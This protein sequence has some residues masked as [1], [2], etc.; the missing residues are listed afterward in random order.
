M[1]RT[2]KSKPKAKRVEDSPQV[3]A[4]EPKGG[5]AQTAE[6]A[7]PPAPPQA[8][9]AAAAEDS[10]K[11]AQTAEEAGAA[12][13]SEE[14]AQD[15]ALQPVAELEAELAQAKDQL[16]RA[17]AETE[18]VRRRARRDLEDASKYAIAVFAKSL[19]AVADN[20]R[21]ALDSIPATGS[22]KPA[23]AGEEPAEAGEE[24]A[25]SGEE[26]KLLKHLAEGV[27]I[28]E[29]ELLTAFEKHGIRKIEPLGE[30][31]DHGF[32][33]AM[34]EVEDADKPAGTI[35]QILEPGYLIHDRLLRPAM[36][37]VAKDKAKDKSEDDEGKSDGDEDK[38]D[39][40]AQSSQV[41]SPTEKSI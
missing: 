37:A 9:A 15:E 3:K 16:L 13:V 36:V 28:V 34:F 33:Q 26:N 30:K 22:G 40:G 27:E 41:D 4:V 6:E 7:A 1:A 18:N 11:A 25:K 19:L 5:A 24:P 8:E 20:L 32:H 39:E 35:V 10:G 29:R 21:R 2:R 31:F 14:A 12:E 23:E 17:L 38:S